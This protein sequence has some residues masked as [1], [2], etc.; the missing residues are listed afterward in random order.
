MLR[1]QETTR[2]FKKIFP[3]FPGPD[4]LGKQILIGMVAGAISGL[5]AL[6]F[7]ILLDFT[8]HLF[9]ESLAG[10]CPPAPSGEK[11]GGE[12]GPQIHHLWLFF[13]PALGG[14]LSG[15]IVYTFAPESEGHGT[16][17]VI[18]AYHQAG[19]YIRT[20][21]PIVKTI[22]SAITIGSGGSA[23]RE[24]P[25][26]HIGAGLGSSLARL[27]KL[28]DRD[29]RLFLVA[30]AAG[31]IGSIF[32]A[33]LGGAL[34]AVEVLYSDTEFES[35]GVIASI[36][37]SLVGYSIFSS[38]F[39]WNP[40]FSIPP[41]S[42]QHPSQ[43]VTYAVLGV[44]LS[45]AGWLYVR[46]FYGVRERFSRL[47]IP[48]FL[49]PALGGLAVG[50]IAIMVPQALGMGYGYLQQAI[51][52][53]LAVKTM[54]MI[55]LVKIIATSFTVGSGGSG[56]VFAPSLVIGGMV[57]GVFGG[58]ARA[59]F[60]GVVPEPAAFILVGMGGMLAGIGKVPIAALVMVAE[61]SAGYQLLV[62]MML[63]SMISYLLTSST[64][65]YREQ[66]ASKVES[67]AHQGEFFVDILEGIR[68]GDFLRKDRDLILI[69][70][71][72]HLSDIILMMSET[73]QNYFPVINRTGDFTGIFSVDDV[74]KLVT[75]NH[76]N[77]L[78]IA[79]DIATSEVIVL[80]PDEDLARAMG[81]FTVKNLDELPVVDRE[82]HRKLLGMLSR[83]EAINAYNQKAAEA[84]SGTGRK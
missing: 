20:R 65:L 64:R 30:G 67:P 16:D 49:K 52:G 45:G 63:V 62:P 61:M 27:L 1:S 79:K 77:Q 82:N 33:P 71:H 29:R 28:S 54:L 68:V 6:L 73:T 81:K 53:D 41:I 78:V 58:L 4:W 59:L 10:Y 75:Q 69:P 36:I 12:C 14:L 51:D 38:I 3:R 47:S 35:E 2:A 19:S 43:L 57:G 7:F 72:T 60:P 70:E 56:G 39:G 32:R 18:R 74:R 55:A 40:I 13:V 26:I 24:G 37:S 23:G 66:V 46:S 8:S 21:I 31:G 80:T 42:Y 44:V 5:G 48:N 22:A 83:R 84:R 17:A 9:L 15:I 25:I 34:F 50:L 11:L 76:L